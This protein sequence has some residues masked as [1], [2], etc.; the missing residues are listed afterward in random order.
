MDAATALIV[1][2][3]QRAFDDVRYWSPTARRN[4]PGCEANV[5]D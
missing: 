3:V 4:N 1:V 2:D 5:G